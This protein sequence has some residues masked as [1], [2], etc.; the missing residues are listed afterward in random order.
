M[1]WITSL[2]VNKI[3]KNASIIVR[4]RANNLFLRELYETV[5]TILLTEKA[6]PEKKL[7]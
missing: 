2:K 4:S 5:G 6:M 3:S 7:W 1:L